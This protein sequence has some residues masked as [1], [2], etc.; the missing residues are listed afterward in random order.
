MPTDPKLWLENVV[1]DS[2]NKQVIVNFWF[3]LYH[4]FSLSNGNIESV[5]SLTSQYKDEVISILNKNRSYNPSDDH[6]RDI[7]TQ[8][9]NLTM[10]FDEESIYKS[11]SYLIKMLASNDEKQP[12]INAKDFLINELISDD[13]KRMIAMFGH[14]TLEALIVYVLSQLYTSDSNTLVRVASLVDQLERNVRSHGLLI[15][16]RGRKTN[17]HLHE[18]ES[19]SQSKKMEKMFPIGSS[20]V[21]LMADRGMITLSSEISRIVQV[22]KKHGSYYLPS[23]LYALSNFDISLLP[24]KFNLPMV[25]K[26]KDW[27]SSSKKPR[28]LSDL[29]GGYLTGITGDLSR[30]SLLSS[31]YIK[32]TLQ[33]LLPFLYIL[34]SSTIMFSFYPDHCW[35][36][37][38]ECAGEEGPSSSNAQPRLE[39][40]LGP[41]PGPTAEEIES[42]LSSFLSTFGSR[43]VTPGVLR[44]TITK[45]SLNTASP[46]K[47]LKIREQMGHLKNMPVPPH[48]ARDALLK[49]LAQWE[50]ERTY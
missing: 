8:I 33:M 49:A 1:S 22:Q 36:L 7:Q 34:I 21:E 19:D 44:D 18:K 15:T 48:L 41:P 29:K 39:L 20:L 6:L 17:T 43:G 47:L 25:C 35:L 10:R 9:E 50:R 5:K 12:S 24:I 40:T 26:P 38:A 11:N 31:N 37:R 14:Y 45:L 3:K 32:M 27:T 28:S 42:E 30:Y 4:D 13:D 46:A 16:R 23:S 2:S